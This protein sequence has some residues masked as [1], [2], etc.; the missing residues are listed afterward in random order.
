MS[1]AILY[2]VFAE[3]TVGLLCEQEKAG[4]PSCFVQKPKNYS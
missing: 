4:L 2:R 1:S 3:M